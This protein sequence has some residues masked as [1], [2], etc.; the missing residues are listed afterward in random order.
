[1]RA[2]KRKSSSL[3]LI[4]FF[5]DFSR[6]NTKKQEKKVTKPSKKEVYFYEKIRKSSILINFR[7]KTAHFPLFSSF[8]K[9]GGLNHKKMPIEFS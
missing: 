6:K 1:M 5:I 2:K 4:V 7:R 3:I 9:K 8:S